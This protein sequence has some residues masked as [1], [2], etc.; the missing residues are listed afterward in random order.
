MSEA[1]LP[2]PQYAFMARCWV[3]AQGLYLLPCINLYSSL[4]FF[5]ARAVFHW[6]VCVI[7]LCNVFIY[8]FVSAPRLTPIGDHAVQVYSRR[9]EK[10]EYE[11]VSKSFRTGR[12]E[13]E[14]QTIQFSVTRCSCIA[15]L[16]VSLVSFAAITLCVASQRVFIAVNVYFVI[17]S[18]RKLLV[19]GYRIQPSL[20]RNTQTGE[21]V[22]L[23]KKS[24]ERPAEYTHLLR[25]RR[26]V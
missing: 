23:K 11:G 2:L 7:D 19:T 14:L 10:K 22:Y 6:S 12:L 3:K 13:R 24:T 9:E 8:K 20:H 1:I 26:R 5:L 18:V 25:S 15:I 21:S 17:D 16:W 4:I